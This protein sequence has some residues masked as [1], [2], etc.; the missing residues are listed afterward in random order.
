MSDVLFL[1]IGLGTFALLALYARASAACEGRHDRTS[2]RPRRRP[3]A[4][5][6]SRRD[7]APARAVLIDAPGAIPM[8]LIG[9]LQIGL[10]FARRARPRQ[11]ARPL[12]WRGSSR[13]AHLALAGPR[14][15]RARLLRRSPAS[16]RRRSRAGSAIRSPCSPSARPASSSLY[17]I[18]RLQ[19]CLP[20][21]PQGFAGV[22]PD[23]AF[24]TAV[25]FVTNTNWQSYGGETTMSHFSQ[26]A[27]LTV[28]NFV[29]AATGI[30]LALGADARLRAL[31]RG[32]DRQFLGR[33]D[34]R[35]ALRAA[36][37]RRSSWRSPSSPWACRR[38]SHGSVDGD[39]ARRRQADHRAR[40]GRQPGGDQAA[41]HQ[42]RRLLQRQ[43]RASLREPERAVELSST[44]SPCSSISAAL[45]YAFGQMVGDRRQGWAFLAAIGILLI[46]GVGVVYWAETAGN[47]ILTGARPRSRAAATW[48][49]RRSASARPMTA[50]YAAVTTGLSDGGVNAMHGS[51]HAARRPRADVPD[52]ARR[53]AAGRRRLGPL[54]HDRLRHPRGLRRRADGRAHARVSRQEDR[55]ARDE[56]RH[57]GGAHPAAG[58]PRLHRR[59]G[60]AARRRW[61]ASAPAA[62]TGCPRSSTPTP[63]RPA[64]TA[65]PSPA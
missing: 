40:P 46:A 20:L 28:Q 17:A 16:I 4:R 18:L 21:N 51:L 34:P 13:R 45:V 63:R 15:G 59:L 33:S 9:W 6:L 3:G 27:G 35:D 55:G 29:S 53:D 54:R 11:A 2:H 12:S 65:R 56:I 23:L 57:A 26:M 19:A 60:H 8:S 22:P 41:R 24:N 52:P 14:P 62:R 32:D 5:R 50:L 30:A 39:D 10:L 31:G 7:A 58:H 37:A 49:A 25:S 38:R 44:S 36:A 61:R 47:P 1:A 48:K 64:T 43:C 42:W